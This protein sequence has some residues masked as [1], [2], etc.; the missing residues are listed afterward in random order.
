MTMRLLFSQEIIGRPLVTLAQSLFE[1]EPSA[2]QQAVAGEV[3]AF[4]ESGRD[5]IFF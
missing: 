4:Y 3:V 1:N 2:K 5:D